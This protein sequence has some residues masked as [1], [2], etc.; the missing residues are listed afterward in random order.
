MATIT[1]E[2][3]TWLWAHGATG[4]ANTAS[5]WSV[6]SGPGNVQGYPQAGDTGVNTSGTI[7]GTD[8]HFAGTTLE[9]GGTA[10]PAAL[11]LAGDS[12]TTPADPTFDAETVL[13][14]NVAGNTTPEAS[15]LDA[16]GT[17]INNGTIAANGAADSSFTIAIANA[18]LDGTVE[19]GAFT[20]AGLMSVAAGNAMS[21][22]SDAPE[23]T[24]PLYV[25]NTGS[26]IVDGGSL[27][28]G[29]GAPTLAITAG[30]LEVEN[31]LVN[32]GTNT[33]VV[34]NQSG[35]TGT[36]LVQSGGTLL[37]NLLVLDNDSSLEAGGTL[38][39]AGA[40]VSVGLLSVNANGT[41]DVGSGSLASTENAWIGQEGTG[42]VLNLT[43]GDVTTAG[44][45]VG[46]DTGST[47]TITISGGTLTT[48]DGL[49]I[50]GDGNGLVTVN[51]GGMLATAG[52]EVD[53]SI[54]IVTTPPGSIVSAPEPGS[55]NGTLV[56]NGGSVTDSGGLA[57]GVGGTAIVTVEAGGTFA[58]TGTNA[59]TIGNFEGGTAQLTVNHGLF[60][61]SG[62]ELEIGNAGNASMLVENAGTV[63][64]SL[65]GIGTA[66]DITTTT[67]LQANVTV[68]G[69][70]SVWD[71]AAPNA[72]LAVGDDGTGM[73][74]V[75]GGGVVHDT[76]ALS[77]GGGQTDGAPTSGVGTVSIGTGSTLTAN[78][79]T[80][81]TGAYEFSTG[82][83]TMIVSGA[84]AEVNDTGQAIIGNQAGFGT[85]QIG[86]GGIF[87]ATTVIIADSSFV[88]GHILPG[89][90]AVTVADGTLNAGAIDVG[91]QQYASPVGY[92]NTD[93]SM[94][95]D[96]GGVVAAASIALA[97]GVTMAGGTLESSTAITTPSVFALFAGEVDGYGTVIAPA[98]DTSLVA[99]GG[100][101]EFTGSILAAGATIEGIAALQLDN[102]IG[103][104]ATVV[105]SGAQES[106][107][108][109]GPQITDTIAIDTLQA[110][111]QIVFNNGVT[112]S[113]EQWLGNGTLD[114]FTSGGTYAFTNV[115]LAEGTPPIFSN[116][117]N[118][119]ELVGVEFVSC[120]AAGTRIA[121]PAGQKSVEDLAVG[122]MVLT[123]LDGMPQPIVWIGHREVNCARHPKPQSVWPVRIAAGAFGRGLPSSVLWL[124]PDHSIYVDE[125]L[126]PVKYLINGS[127]IV[128][129]RRRS[130]TYYHIELPDHDA[131]LAEGLATE[132]YLDTGDR[133]NFANAGDAVALFPDFSIHKWEADGCA[134]L[135]V[136]G[137]RFEA[138]RTRLARIAARRRTARKRS[139]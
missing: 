10:G 97:R 76:G 42:A 14:S 52:L 32:A 46:Y 90:G 111:D 50:G 130:I 108:L 91:L 59:F 129:V 33:V 96:A 64:T 21:I 72:S 26:M 69:T 119:V 53:S 68:T 84:G 71:I 12:G 65:S 123:V 30:V 109:G 28:M 99:S 35:D 45:T 39:V 83:A 48:N 60:S 61:T 36:V 132:T 78:G 6:I 7:L 20:N 57:I 86:D 75:S 41:I 3:T 126:I 94:T 101:L 95:I 22:V 70:G 133:S 58:A 82:N 4:F 115:T 106:L 105:F 89:S 74:A 29:G 114:V 54:T 38:D 120:F 66:A 67:S 62:A 136:N 139:A 13:T 138:V 80:L 5:D 24:D 77:A 127:T 135:I 112:V 16:A 116:T 134:E 23:A 47:G 102:A 11:S 79:I 31:G 92:E 124:S 34:G 117:A 25:T 81:G 17:F 128:Q 44:L 85:L 40:T 118:A 2:P 51:Q 63:V 43:G 19:P 55:G 107:I 93:A 131:V 27:L 121:T 113:G 88:E 49:V 37:A 9:L 1:A 104:G 15:V 137:P 18:T 125:V 103:S 122:D 87:T 110:G 98:V 56:V 8:L 73:L 100:T